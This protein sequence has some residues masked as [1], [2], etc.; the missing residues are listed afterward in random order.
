M[1]LYQKLLLIV[2]AIFVVVLIIGLVRYNNNYDR[3][4][5][6]TD[7]YESKIKFEVTHI[8]KE[9]D[10]EPLYTIDVDYYGEIEVPGS[11]YN[12]YLDG[13]N[14]ITVHREELSVHAAASKLG[15]SFDESKERIIY[16]VSYP[17]ESASPFSDAE[18][19]E[20]VEAMK[21]ISYPLEPDNYHALDV[22]FSYDGQMHG[23]DENC[24]SYGAVEYVFD[25]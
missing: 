4:A 5:Y 14:T 19:K 9:K 23:G 13:Y 16:R 11:I 3:I 1:K 10:Q 18:I 21:E 15:K 2:A 22:S 20:A 8:A 12:E 24:L 17:W 25:K 6:K 7:S